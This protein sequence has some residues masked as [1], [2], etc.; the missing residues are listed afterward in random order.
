MPLS[1]DDVREGITCVLSTKVPNPQFEGQT[2]SK[3]GNS[4][5]EGI[6]EAVTNES[7]GTYLEE[8]PS[9]ANKIVDKAILAARARDA[10]VRAVEARRAR[11]HG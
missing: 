4:E 7:L 8:N 1:G 3:L 6:V 2:K 5:V 10:Y 9:V 11:A